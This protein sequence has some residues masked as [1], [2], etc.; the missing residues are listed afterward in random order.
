VTFEK[1]TTTQAWLPPITHNAR[2]APR[3]VGIELEFTG[4]SH[5]QT[6]AAVAAWAGT[7][8]TF[9]SL[10]QATVKHPELGEFEIEVDWRYLKEE[11]QEQQITEGSESWVKF[12]RQAARLLVPVE[13]VAPPIGVDQLPQLEG[14]VNSLRGA[15]AQGTEDSPLAAYGL[16]I[17]AE[18][19]AVTAEAVLPYLQA[20]CLLQWWLVEHHQVDV[21]RRLSPW[22]H[23]YPDAYLHLVLGYWETPSLDQ[24]IT[25]YHEH[26]PT[27]NRALDMWPLFAHYDGER[28]DQLMHEPLIKARPTF[29]YRL[30]NCNVDKPDWHLWQEWQA[31]LAIER[32]AADDAARQRLIGVFFSVKRP[33]LGVHKKQWIETIDQWLKDPS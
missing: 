18:V 4:L 8:A 5:A 2:G 31:W 12:L 19:P 26:N 33:W 13:V 32:L 21:T 3:T 16:H 10:V 7:E 15:G 29:H 23:L 20:F 30:P 11:A 24:M 14:L 17:N 22:V 27:R 28:V 25:D 6:T 1:P 9:Q